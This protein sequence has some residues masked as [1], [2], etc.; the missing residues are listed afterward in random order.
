MAYTCIVYVMKSTPPR[1]FSV[2]FELSAI[3]QM[4]MKIFLDE[5]AILNN[6]SVLNYAN[7]RPLYILNNR[8]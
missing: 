7:F 5:K 3:L 8:I 2:S 4:C 1:L 6:S